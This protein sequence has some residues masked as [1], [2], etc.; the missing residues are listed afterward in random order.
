MPLCSVGVEREKVG[1][2]AAAAI[3]AQLY[4]EEQWAAV[5]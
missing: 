2:G 5:L 4:E 1:G 3:V